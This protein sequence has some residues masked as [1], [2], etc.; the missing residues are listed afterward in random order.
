MAKDKF[1]CVRVSRGF[2][3]GKDSQGRVYYLGYSAVIDES[4]SGFE[5]G[6]TAPSMSTLHSAWEQVAGVPLEPLLVVKTRIYSDS[7]FSEE[8]GDGLPGEK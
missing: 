6:I 1:G 2:T 5:L 3:R 8:D 7:D 4:V